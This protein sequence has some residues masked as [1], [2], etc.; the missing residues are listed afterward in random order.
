M[1]AEKVAAGLTRLLAGDPFARGLGIELLE[2]EPGRARAAMTVSDA[3]RNFNGFIHGGAIFTLLDQAFAAA[4]NS[5][6]QSAVAISM[7]VQFVN[8]PSPG[9]R[10]IAEARELHRSRKLGLYEMVVTEEGGRLIC[11]S[12][13]RVYRIGEPIVNEDGEKA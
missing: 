2:V 9:A 3:H 7:S 1:S 10:L 13:G 4:S 12:E 6:N 5:H 11:R 8:A